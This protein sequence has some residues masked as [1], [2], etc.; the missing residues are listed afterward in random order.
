MPNAV[1]GGLSPGAS[2]ARPAPSQGHCSVWVA[3]PAFGTPLPLARMS[4]PGLTP[5]SF[6]LQSWLPPLSS[7][8]PPVMW[9]GLG[10]YL[11]QSQP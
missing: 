9:G 7:V 5:I 2:R 11:P 4:S 3:P 8:S 10:Q 6:H 1:P